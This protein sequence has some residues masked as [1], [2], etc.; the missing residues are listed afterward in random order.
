MK[1]PLS[2]SAAIHIY[3]EICPLGPFSY[4]LVWL[5][6]QLHL[7][8]VLAPSTAALTPGEGNK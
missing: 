1:I 6:F 4:L 7:G 3:L 2:G 8:D 5:V